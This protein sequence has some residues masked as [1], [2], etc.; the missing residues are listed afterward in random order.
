M[1]SA[2]C[3][4]KCQTTP[5]DRSKS[6]RCASNLRDY[7]VVLVQAGYEVRRQD[8]QHMESRRECRAALEGV[9]K[10]RQGSLLL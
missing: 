3:I 1:K 7:L 6:G 5:Q 10:G 2:A 8:L 4:I 9:L